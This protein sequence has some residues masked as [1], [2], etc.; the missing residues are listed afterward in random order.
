MATELP[1][2]ELNII[3]MEQIRSAS[4]NAP[5]KE[6]A[7]QMC[8]DCVLDVLVYAYTFGEDAV[9]E[10]LGTDIRLD[11]DNRIDT[12]YKSVGG[13]DFEQRVSEYVDSG[14]I[15]D[16]SRVIDTDAHRVYNSSMLDTARAAGA[17]SKTWLTQEDDK[18][19]DPHWVLG[20]VTVGIDERFY[21]DGASAMY[22]GD[23][24][25]ADLDCN[26]RCYLTFSR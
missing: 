2:D 21:T 3:A 10:M 11:T 19:R 17:K 13:K 4:Q 22:P 16:I 18:V 5:D 6:T 26:C 1:I 7:K 15:E 12:I 9:N 14:Q 24:G 23:F 25:V 8:V 20:G